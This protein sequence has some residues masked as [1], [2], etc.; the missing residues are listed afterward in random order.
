[1]PSV[2]LLFFLCPPIPSNRRKTERGRGE[3]AQQGASDQER[4][5]EAVALFRLV[6]IGLDDREGLACDDD[7]HIGFGEE[8]GAFGTAIHWGY[9][10]GSRA[11]AGACGRNRLARET[12]PCFSRVGDAIYG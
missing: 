6:D 11:R 7:G 2:R 8:S 3:Q 9:C 5:V 10:V 12:S 4:A 1:M